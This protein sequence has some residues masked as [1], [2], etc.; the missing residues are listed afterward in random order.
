MA[1]RVGAIVAL[2]LVLVIAALAPALGLL[3]GCSGGG[4]DGGRGGASGGGGPVAGTGLGEV[5]PAG[6][7]VSLASGPAAG[8]L[9][10]IPAG[11]LAAPL[12]IQLDAA[13]DIT[14]AGAVPV[15][16]A[17]R[18]APEGTAFAV[19][20]TVTVP[21]VTA[22][23]PAGMGAGDI[24]VLHRDAAGGVSDL[25]SVGLDT[26]GGRVSAATAG[27]S[28]FQ[29]A[30][31]PAPPL[32]SVSQQAIDFGAVAAGA[33]ADRGIV[34]ENA[35]GGLLTG[36]AAAAPP[37]SVVG[38]GAYA[39]AAG[40]RATI[41]VRFAPATGG[42]FA[43]PLDLSGGGG[44]Q[45]ALAGSSGTSAP[46][47][48]S[49]TTA[50]ID[51]G[52]VAPGASADRAISVR[53]VGGGTLTG[54]A[55]VSAPYSINGAASYALSSAAS[56][57][58]VVRFEPSFAGTFTA[59]LALTGGGGA[60]VPLSGLG[61]TAGGGAGI[62]TPGLAS[63]G[64]IGLGGAVDRA[65]TV[66]CTGSVPLVGSVLATPPFSV[67]GASTYGLSPGQSTT[68]T[69]RFAPS[70]PGLVVGSLQ[71]SGVS[72]SA[73]TVTGHGGGPLAAGPVLAVAEPRDLALERID[74]DGSLDAVVGQGGSTAFILK[75]DGALGFSILGT[76]FAGADQDRVVAN[77]FDRDGHMDVACA[78]ADPGT[79][80][81]IWGDAAAT[82]TITTTIDLAATA[83]GP[84]SADALV[85]AD[86]NRDA[87]LDLIVAR[88]TA[89]RISVLQGS[90]R[91]FAASAGGVVT[92][93]ADIAVADID[94]DGKL[95]VV[96]AA[97]G[98]VALLSG[99]GA[100][101]LAILGGA[102]GLARA[103][104]VAVL[105]LDHA[106]LLDVAVLDADGASVA[107]WRNDG[108]GA[109]TRLA[110]V[111]TGPS[112]T[113]FVA[114]DLD[115]DGEADLAVALAGSGG[116]ALRKNLGGG[117]AFAPLPS[118]AVPGEQTAIAAGDVDADGAVDLVVAR[119]T[120]PG[121]GE[122]VVL[123]GLVPVP[124]TPGFEVAGVPL[125]SASDS[126][127]FVM[128]ISGS[129]EFAPPEPFVDYRGFPM[130]GNKLE[131]SKSTIAGAIMSLPSSHR[132]A[133]YAFDC[134]IYRWRAAPVFADANSRAS[135]IAW[136]YSLQ[137][138]GATATGPAIARALLD[139]PSNLAIVMAGDGDFN[140]G[141]NGASGH[142]R[143]VQAAN[144][145]GAQVHMVG[146]G[147]SGTA[148]QFYRTFTT[149]SGGTY[150]PIP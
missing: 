130:V 122:V 47:L 96:A 110:D 144:I 85:A 16:P 1:A 20:A 82:M 120:A 2:R 88:R 92:G 12:S 76:P 72:P 93:P 134:D 45:V 86:L 32:I 101:G 44:A 64:A 60:A 138:I 73:V 124:L 100:G 109:L 148:E 65:F 114:T 24:V 42:A 57:N 34:V 69:I 121:A 3:A 30:V 54:T 95:D 18:F 150:I 37:F 25:P 15:G 41:V 83:A 108:G 66:S 117:R 104:R 84:G 141:A 71:F 75:G 9:V 62:V 26:A 142:Q 149:D 77:D 128:D 4:G 112:P 67:I 90:G 23:L 46:P 49:V 8:A 10:A 35:G 78:D 7:V 140:C 98:G 113:A 91:T 56:A 136:V 133:V 5:G 31:R 89:G 111:P 17:V 143:M 48:I 63:F 21:F 38:S 68:V 87:R 40:G 33:S 94:G 125:T 123:R 80:T 126:V 146:I 119:I 99:N 103:T 127:F 139:D 131:R 145:Q 29:A 115:G 81:V 22:R 28:T 52:L 79:I 43:G 19:P 27:F 147:I 51:F 14:S 39:L 137:V 58:I 70:H 107:L 53:N 11:A 132:F 97:E 118:P 135:A 6:G 106:G 102:T 61:A 36:T 116:P 74:A 59:T 129:M 50:P 13:A 105:D 55:T